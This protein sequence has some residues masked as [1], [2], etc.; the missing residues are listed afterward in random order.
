MSNDLAMLLAHPLSYWCCSAFLAEHE[1]LQQY[2]RSGRHRCMEPPP[3][4][5]TRKTSIHL[6]TRTVNQGA[7]SGMPHLVI[8]LQIAD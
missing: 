4:P 5:R 3:G 6:A 8:R 2:I 7:G 1:C